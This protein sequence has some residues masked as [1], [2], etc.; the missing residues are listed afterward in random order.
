MKN[1]EIY[2]IELLNKQHDKKHFTCGEKSLDVYLQTQASQDMQRYVSA[3]Y[4]LTKINDHEVIGYYTLSSS[5]IETNLLEMT[6]L[7]RLP[8]Y[9]LLPAT[10]LGRLAVATAYQDKKLGAHLLMDALKRCY[11]AG[12]HIA[13]V[14]VV[15]DAKNEQAE[16]FYKRFG[17]QQFID[18]TNKLFLMMDTIKKSGLI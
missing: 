4:V 18:K 2:H 13:S 9:P 15:V 11:H 14:A 1:D 16:E 7:K 10:L 6:I 8:K 12:R 5:N 17:F 3:T